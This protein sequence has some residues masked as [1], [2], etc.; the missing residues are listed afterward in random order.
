MAFVLL[1]MV[2]LIT[3]NV[4]SF[5]IYLVF[6]FITLEPTPST[7]RKVSLALSSSRE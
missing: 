7:G 4:F 1:S 5:A 2:L 3:E 6:F